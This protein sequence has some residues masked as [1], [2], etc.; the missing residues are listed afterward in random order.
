MAAPAIP[1]PVVALSEYKD[2]HPLAHRLRT[3]AIA[4]VRMSGDHIIDTWFVQ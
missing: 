3:R 1:A 2:V 4:T